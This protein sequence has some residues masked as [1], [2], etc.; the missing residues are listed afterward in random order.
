MGAQLSDRSAQKAAK[1]H[2]VLV[3]DD[4]EDVVESVR[5]LLRLE[6]RVLGATH[7][8]DALRLLETEDVHVIMSDQRMPEMS[9][10]EFLRHARTSNPEAMRLLFTGYAD[11]RAVIDAIN[12]GNVFRYVAKPWDPDELLTILR[13]AVD[14]Y[15]LGARLKERLFFESALRRYLAAPIVEELIHD[16]S[17]LRLGGEKRELTV[18]FFDVADFTSIAESLQADEL[19][20]L[21]NRYLDALVDAIFKHGGTLDK[22]IGDAVMAFWGAP[23]S[24]PDHAARALRAAVDMQRALRA[25]ADSQSDPRVRG[26]HGRIGVHTGVAA[27][28]NLG[29]ST[30]MNYTVMCDTVNVAARLE[31]INKHYGTSISASQATLER[32]GW[33]DARE[34][35]TVRVR[36]RAASMRVFEVFDPTPGAAGAAP[37]SAAL[38]AYAEGLALY[39]ERRFV[40]ARSAFERALTSG[41]HACAATMAA[42]AGSLALVPPSEG[43]DGAHSLDR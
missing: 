26:L 10:V 40:E 37:P 34:L 33:T 4:E 2:T 19:V 5:D 9:G 30:V 25:F 29:S 38:E 31:R 13:D 12:Q 8:R 3:V 32:A 16:P 42:R 24:Q 36:G 21:V 22:F 6:F 27:I 7:A 41:D 17:R 20:T 1:K 39:R 23:L 43:W 14:R 18:L 35:D 15:E 11:I 28:G